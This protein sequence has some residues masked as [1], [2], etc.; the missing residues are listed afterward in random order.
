MSLKLFTSSSNHEAA[1]ALIVAKYNGVS[2]ETPPFNV[3]VDNKTPE[4]L[5]KNPTGSL[6]ILETEAGVIFESNAIARYVV[7]LN[8][9]AHLYGQSPFETSTI[10]SWLDFANSEI[11]IPSN[12]ILPGL[13]GQ[14]P[15]DNKKSCRS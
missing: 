8:D 13:F 1:K 5:E 4:F 11:K 6:P 10:D 14:G 15:Y 3:G 12:D 7:R 2:I 9:V